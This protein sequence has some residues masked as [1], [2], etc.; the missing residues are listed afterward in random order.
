MNEARLGILIVGIFAIIVGF[1]IMYKKL[2]FYGLIFVI[3]SII[4]IVVIFLVKPVELYSNFKIE[5]DLKE[6]YN[7]KKYD[8]LKEENS[9]KET[10]RT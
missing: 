10:Q 2:I 6:T 1:Y 4:G 9:V 3:L 8:R 5:E 7:T